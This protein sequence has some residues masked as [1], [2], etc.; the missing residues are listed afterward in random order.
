MKTY[1]PGSWSM[2]L[3]SVLVL[4]MLVLVKRNLLFLLVDFYIKNLIENPNPNTKTEI[5]NTDRKHQKSFEMC[6]N[7][8]VYYYGSFISS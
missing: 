8:T 2:V 6:M 4:A 7:Y 5:P 1:N 3:V